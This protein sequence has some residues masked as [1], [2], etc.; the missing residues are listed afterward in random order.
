MFKSS[1]YPLILAENTWIYAGL[2]L[3]R[4]DLTDLTPYVLQKIQFET[5]RSVRREIEVIQG[6]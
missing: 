6:S 4:F 1:P 5:V 2:C 3:N